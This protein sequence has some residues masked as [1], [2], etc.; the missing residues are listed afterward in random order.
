[1]RFLM[2]SK[3]ILFITAA[4]NAIFIAL[5]SLQIAFFRV[6]P[7][8]LGL[9]TLLVVLAM[10]GVAFVL[11][12]ICLVKRKKLESSIPLFAVIIAFVAWHLLSTDDYSIFVRFKM[13][14]SQYNA[15]ISGARCTVRGGCLSSAD[16]P[17][18]IVFPFEGLAASVGIVY[19][20]D[21]RMD[22]FLARPQTFSSEVSCSSKPISGNFYVCGFY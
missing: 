13:E 16:L 22:K 17:G 9:L 8:P 6:I 4:C 5:L 3:N 21:G 12:V 19:A 11:S 14:E 1:M 15:A 18:F 7:F 20:P 2:N 10:G